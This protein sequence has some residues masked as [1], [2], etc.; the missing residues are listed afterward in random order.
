MRAGDFLHAPPGTAHVLVGAGEGPCVIVMAGARKDSLETLFP[1]SEVAARYGASVD[2]ETSDP[3]TAYA[4]TV[5]PKPAS[6]GLP[7]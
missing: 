7:W 5:A 2:V 1:A 6:L 3:A 4:G